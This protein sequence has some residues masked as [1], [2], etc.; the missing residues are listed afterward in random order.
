M[1]LGPRLECARHA[2]CSARGKMDKTLRKRCRAT[3]SPALPVSFALLAVL[4]SRAAAQAPAP[5]PSPTPVPAAAPA[6]APKWYEEIDVHGM[7]SAAYSY[8]TNRPDSGLN[9]YRVFD[10]QDNTFRL[11]VA[12]LTV[13][14]N[15]AKPGEAGFRVD[16]EAGSTIPQVSASYGLFQGQDF[17]LKQ[18]FVTWVA[19][20]GSGLKID[21]GK[22]ISHFNYEYIESWD[23]LND[24]ST[25]S[26]TFGYAIPYAHTGFRLGYAFSD[27]WAALVM[28]VNGWDDVKDNNSS[29]SV[30]AQVTWTPVKALSVAANLMTGPERP[31]VNANPRTVWELVGQWKL[32]DL[33]VFGLDLLYAY[34]RGAVV[35]GQT[36]TWASVVGYA[37]LGV[38]GLFAVCLRAEYFDDADGARTGVAQRLRELTLT[39]EFRVSSHF[40]FRADF[41]VDWSNVASFEK[42]GGA[43]SKTQ[44]TVNVN[45]IYLF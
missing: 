36:A 37:R 19:P 6:P 11:D 42:K 39:P 41:R 5:G 14:K 21:F 4:S 13:M 43:T 31:D 45:A 38:S 32:S 25:H 26:F 7:V 3:F 44:P 18:A 27:Q 33:T 35:P 30:G 29:K 20:L 17:D 1:R 28:L 23:T 40:L 8:N 12:E 16:A 22:F 15:A 9:Q 10:F 2:P 34:E 24:N